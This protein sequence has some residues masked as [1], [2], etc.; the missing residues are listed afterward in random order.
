MLRVW[1][2]GSDSRFDE[3][4]QHFWPYLG[5]WVFQMAWVWVVSLPVTAIN[6]SPEDTNIGPLDILGWSV[7][8]LGLTLE[9]LADLERFRFNQDKK[10]R[11]DGLSDSSSQ[12]D[13]RHES[14]FLHSGL[15]SLSRH[16]NYFGEILVWFG[17]WLSSI[18]SYAPANV[19]IVFVSLL[20]PATTILL[21]CFISGA[22]LA[23]WRAN[24]TYGKM[25]E[26]LAYRDK[27]SPFIPFPP[28]LY[29]RLSPMTKRFLF[30]D[31]PY[32]ERHLSPALSPLRGSE[33]NKQD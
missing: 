21:V 26:Y 10:T 12:G 11:E 28:S 24:R 23:E 25:S 4:R 13:D 31:I 7:Y 15:W 9:S 8:A 33:G 1:I 6:S 5:F 30:L 27:T 3:M 20:S 16:P 14:R 29:R 18:Q 17:F 19:G 32:Y 2:R 22:N